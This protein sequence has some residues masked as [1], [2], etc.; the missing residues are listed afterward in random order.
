M[1]GPPTYHAFIRF[2]IKDAGAMLAKENNLITLIELLTI[3][4]GKKSAILVEYSVK[5][6]HFSVHA[7]IT[8]KGVK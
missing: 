2:L 5:T 4:L 6:F 7:I 3:M 8:C 1:T